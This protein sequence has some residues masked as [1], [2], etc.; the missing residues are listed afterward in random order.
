MARGRSRV[1]A[2]KLAWL[3]NLEE[4][5]AQFR[6]IY[7]VPPSITLKYYHYDNLL[8]INQDEIY[9]PIM[10]V[11]EG[12]FRF[13][14]HPFLIEFLQTVNASPCQ[15]FVNVFRIV[16]GVVALNQILGINLTP[17]EI[18][19]VYQYMC[20]GLESRTSCH[21]RA[22]ELNVKLVNGLPDS[23]KGYD[24][25]YLV[26]LGHWFTGGASC[27]NLYGFPG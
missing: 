10:A 17:K 13:P 23:N 4:R 12:G 6:E 15:V 21:L 26:V 8:P 7:R 1:R 11:V 5:M 19:Y 14:L 16:M 20:L 2:S 3:V 18:L 22:R 27:R 25:D 9:L 24:K